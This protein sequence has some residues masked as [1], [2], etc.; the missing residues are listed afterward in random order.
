MNVIDDKFDFESYF[1]ENQDEGAKVRP[2]SQWCD[3]VIDR[4]FGQSAPTSWTPIGFSKASGN[5]DLRPGE[6]TI[7]AGV[8][9]NGKTTYLSQVMLNVM[10]SGQK[11]CLASLEMKPRDSMYKMTLQALGLPNPSAA[12]IRAFHKWTDSRLWVYDH[13]GKVAASRMLAVATYVR[14]ELG[15]DH[16]VIDSLMKCGV[17][18]DD[19]TA[20]KLFVDAIC[21]I[22]RDTCMHI[23]L[24]AHSKK[25]KD[26]MTPPG[27]MDVKGSGAI[28]DQVDNVITVWRNK[29][30][31]T[32]LS[33]GAQD[34]RGEPD[35]L[36]ICDKQRNGEWEGQIGLWFDKNSQQFLGNPGDE[37]LSLYVHPEEN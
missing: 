30:K 9:G 27:K 33:E 14:K 2:A 3:E 16:I 32:S 1:V 37:P 6:V 5:F 24:V 25:Q 36:L 19:Y 20:Q 23:H 29:P 13:L 7:W 28:T 4:V 8:N 21:T 31:E 26:E 15:I 17:G 34:R 22:A 10:E 35:A 12:F 11:V 18:V